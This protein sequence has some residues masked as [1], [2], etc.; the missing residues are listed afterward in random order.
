[1]NR[2]IA[3]R[4]S[5]VA[6]SLSLLGQKN[7]TAI[8]LKRLGPLDINEFEFVVEDITV[9]ILEF[10]CIGSYKRPHENCWA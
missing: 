7:Q 3:P 4:N 9:L 8:R 10:D 2:S 1:M 6:K 5:S